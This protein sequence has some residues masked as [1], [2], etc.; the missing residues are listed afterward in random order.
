MTAFSL[1][2]I[3]HC[4]SLEMYTGKP[5]ISIFLPDQKI[6]IKPAACRG[7]SA[8]SKNRA[9]CIIWSLIWQEKPFC[10]SI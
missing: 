3:L 5:Y 10:Y 7:E 6:L 2:N 9:G 1:L 4:Q 8:K